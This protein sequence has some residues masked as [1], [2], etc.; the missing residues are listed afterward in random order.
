MEKFG[1]KRV[2]IKGPKDKRLITAVFAVTK[3]GYFYHH[4]LSTKEK[5]VDVCR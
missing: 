1:M 2:E 3:D 5:P 4:K